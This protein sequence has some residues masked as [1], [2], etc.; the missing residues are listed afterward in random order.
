MREMGICSIGIHKLQYNQP[1]PLQI[2]SQQPSITKPVYLIHSVLHDYKQ[3]QQNF[4]WLVV[5]DRL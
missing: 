5:I 1:F 4:G 2:D 3:L